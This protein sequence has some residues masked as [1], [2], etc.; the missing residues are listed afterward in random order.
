MEFASVAERHVFADDAIRADVATGADLRFGMYNG[1]GMNHFITSRNMNVTSASL[2][3]SSPTLQTPLALPIL[4]RAF[5]SSTSMISVSPGHNRFAPFHVLGGHEIGHLIRGFRLLQ[6]Q[7]P[8]DLRH[9]LK[10]QHARHDGVSG[11]MSLKIRLVHCDVFDADDFAAFDFQN[12]VHHQER[13]AVRQQ[14]HDS[15]DVHRAALGDQR[16]GRGDFRRR[17]GKRLRGAQRLLHLRNDMPDHFA[18]RRVARFD[19]NQMPADRPAEQR[20]IAHNVEHLVP[21]KFLGIPQRFGCQH[22]VVADD[23]GIFQAAALDEAVF[24][25]ELDF[26]VKTKCPCVRQFRLPGLGG[27]FRAV[28]LGE[29][30]F[31][32]RAG[33]GDFEG[34]VGKQ[35]HH[36]LA[37]LQ[38]NRLGGRIRFALFRQRRDAGFLNDFAELARTAVGDGRFVGVQLHDGVVDAITRQRREDVFDGV[39]FHIAPGERR[40]AGRFADI[41]HARLDFRFAF[42]V[43]AA[44]AHAAVGGRRQNR[45]VHPVAVVQADAGKTGGAIKGL[46]IKHGWI[47]QNAG[48]VGKV[49]LQSPPNPDS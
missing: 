36:R 8:G 32:V 39:N 11:E 47:R 46:L 33:A 23:D 13:R 18:I 25:E 35:R 15:L 22:R 29:P 43:H 14:L 7:N 20:Q 9:R 3:T 26:L 10:L 19:G 4:P 48:Q 49:T 42:E 44:E 45:H 41:F 16:R 2:T 40:R 24:D 21:H 27:D 1:G 12:A 34:L 17:R 30:A 28:K 6:K 5:V 37:H 31:F 38:F